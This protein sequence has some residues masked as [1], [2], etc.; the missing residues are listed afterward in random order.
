MGG[1]GSVCLDEGSH[2]GSL[3]GVGGF[4]V[5]FVVGVVLWLGGL[6]V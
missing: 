1:G 6:W 2:L 4:G 3:G 5:R